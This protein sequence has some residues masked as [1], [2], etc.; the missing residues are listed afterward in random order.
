[1]I[2]TMAKKA[3]TSIAANLAAMF[4]NARPSKDTT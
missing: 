4:G 1:V 2:R 3:T